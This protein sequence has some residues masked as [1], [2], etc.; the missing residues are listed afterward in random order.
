[1]TLSH[2]YR[3]ASPG[4]P[5][6]VAREISRRAGEKTGE[7]EGTNAAD[8]SGAPADQT[9]HQ[10]Q[11][12]GCL[13]WVLSTSISTRRGGLTGGLPDVGRSPTPTKA[14]LRFLSQLWEG[15]TGP[16]LVGTSNYFAPF[17]GL[18]SL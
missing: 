1:M 7:G 18:F 9:R 8:R 2:L 15:L 6:R 10:S 16:V 14:L 3:D 17:G 12:R 5:P 11:S 4:G 13:W